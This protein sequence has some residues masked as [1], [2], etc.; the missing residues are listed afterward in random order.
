MQ[1]PNRQ[2][3]FGAMAGLPNLGLQAQPQQPPSQA[4]ASA[5]RPAPGGGMSGGGMSGSGASG[6]GQAAPG[7]GG[8]TTDDPA[9][10][11]SV[12]K[13]LETGAADP[14]V[15]KLERRI[16]EMTRN[17]RAGPELMSVKRQLFDRYYP[18]MVERGARLDREQYARDVF[19]EV[20]NVRL[21]ALAEELGLDHS[22]Q[23]LLAH[24][25]LA[26]VYEERGEYGE[27][28]QH[29]VA[30]RDLLKSGRINL[31]GLGPEV[32]RQ[33]TAAIESVVTRL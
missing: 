29:L 3:P 23:A 20:Y 15:V 31:N 26:G 18:A 8:H 25:L 4:A 13:S 27:A 6:A 24:L 7:A 5:G 14:E 12:Q 11:E 28:E 30:V 22:P 19:F 32:N 2:N 16:N 21:I 9:F 33:I 10:I 17:G 1:Q